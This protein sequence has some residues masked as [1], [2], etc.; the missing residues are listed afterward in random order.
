MA[1]APVVA[2]GFNRLSPGPIRRLWYAEL[3]WLAFV[4]VQALDGAMSYIGVS[5]HGLGIEAN[6]LVAWYLGVLGPA[7][8][9]TVAKLFAVTCGA[10]LYVGARYMWVGLLTVVYVIFAVVPWVRLLSGSV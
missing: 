5:L 6:P 10:V 4:I 1:S 2:S 7:A 3:L 8:G 9:F